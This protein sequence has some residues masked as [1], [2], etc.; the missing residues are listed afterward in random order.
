[1]VRLVMIIRLLIN[2][3]FGFLLSICGAGVFAL[4]GF[5]TNLPRMLAGFNMLFRAFF[6]YSY[7]LYAWLLSKLSIFLSNNFGLEMLAPL[8]RVGVCVLISFALGSG[9]LSIFGWTLST[10]WIAIFVTHGLIIGVAWEQ[11]AVPG[12]F[13]M[14][15][16]LQ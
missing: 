8:S 16:R 2:I 1:M 4:V 11:I 13:Q 12:E 15:E 5:A 7:H 6:R 14:G 10:W 3:C 9:I